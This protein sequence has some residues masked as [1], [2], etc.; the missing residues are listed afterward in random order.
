LP[1]ALKDFPSHQNGMVG[2]VKQIFDHVMAPVATG[3]YSQFAVERMTILPN[4][5]IL[6][7]AGS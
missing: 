5:A 3:H 2:V 7:K 6:T 4:I 1:A